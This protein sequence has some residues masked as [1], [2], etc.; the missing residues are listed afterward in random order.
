MYSERRASD[1]LLEMKNGSSYIHS[2]LQLCYKYTQQ[3]L[4]RHVPHTKQ[5]GEVRMHE[6]LDEWL[7]VINVPW[8]AGRRVILSDISY[9]D[10]L[11]RSRGLRE[12][13]RYVG[14]VTLPP[15][16]SKTAKSIGIC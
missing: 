11:E 9:F 13:R 15:I 10:I 5:N 2:E 8:L 6:E 1:V 4:L 3:S 14:R 7:R 12:V 16:F